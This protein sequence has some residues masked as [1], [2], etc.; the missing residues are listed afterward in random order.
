MSTATATAP[1][2]G[3]P[4]ATGKKKLIITLAAVLLLVVVGGVAAL[5]L[6]KGKAV[7]EDDED[8]DLHRPAAAAPGAAP[9]RAP[10]PPPT[11]LPLEMFT[12]NLADRDVDRF[13]Q[14]GITLEVTDNKVSDQ[15]K[16]VMPAVRNR[17]LLAISDR[18]AAELA[19]RE[20]K[21]KLADTVRR[22]TARALGFDMPDPVVKDEEPRP[23]QRPPRRPPEPAPPINA[24]LFSNFIVQ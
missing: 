5:M 15:I 8:A 11:Y 16:A 4:P 1:A 10:G 12:V 9:R 21:E 3:A 2:A 23:G 20:G 18:T 22:E 14:V 7:D 17:I 6:L 13:A 19:T 24:V